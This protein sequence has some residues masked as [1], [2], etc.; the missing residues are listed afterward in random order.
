[1]VVT[2]TSAFPRRPPLSTTRQRSTKAR[3]WPPGSVLSRCPARPQVS[4][5]HLSRSELS[6]FAVLAG[7]CGRAHLIGCPRELGGCSGVRWQVVIGNV[8]MLV[9][10]PLVLQCLG[11]Q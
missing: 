10:S 7:G 3:R 2:T 5:H 8:D 9:V 11:C 1:M 4:R 6:G